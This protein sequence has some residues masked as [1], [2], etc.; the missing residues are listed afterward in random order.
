MSGI[1]WQCVV[2]LIMWHVWC[3][4]LCYMCESLCDM[5]S[6]SLDMCGVTHVCCDSCV[7]WIMCA[8][9][10]VCCDSCVVWLIQRVPSVWLIQRVPWL[11][12]FPFATA[13]YLTHHHAS[14]TSVTWLLHMCDMTPWNMIVRSKEHL[15]GDYNLCCLEIWMFLFNNCATMEEGTRKK[16]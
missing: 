7:V 15:R 5:S 3:D 12:L 9:T 8:V 11:D 6:A 2:W 4:S 13:H 16:K 14:C 10:H 1:T